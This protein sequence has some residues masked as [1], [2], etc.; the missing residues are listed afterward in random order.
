MYRKFDFVMAAVV[1]AILGAAQEIYRI[2][3]EVK[4]NKHRCRRLCERLREIP[5]VQLS[6]DHVAE[7]N[8]DATLRVVEAAQALVEKYRS[9]KW[10]VQVFWCGSGSR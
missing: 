8:L 10:Y 3:E 6:K 2:T 7:T 1:D 4:A 5:L 9:V